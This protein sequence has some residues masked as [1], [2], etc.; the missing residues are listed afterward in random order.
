MRKS[1]EHRELALRREITRRFSNPD[2]IT[3]AIGRAA[4]EAVRQHK[5]AGN[6]IATWRDGK[7]VIIQPEDIVIDEEL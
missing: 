5:L 2:F 1:V 4:R 7:V 3:A 6:P